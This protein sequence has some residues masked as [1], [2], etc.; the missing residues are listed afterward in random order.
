MRTILL[1]A[2]I[3]IHNSSRWKLGQNFIKF[4]QAQGPATDINW[5]LHRN[6]AFASGMDKE[7]CSDIES[8]Q[9]E[10]TLSVSGQIGIMSRMTARGPDVI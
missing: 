9:F 2:T 5:C 4:T 1:L 3:P 7:N 10:E 6:K 8:G